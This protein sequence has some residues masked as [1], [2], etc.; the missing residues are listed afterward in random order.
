MSNIEEKRSNIDIWYNIILTI[1][2]FIKT[3][4]A[5]FFKY[6]IEIRENSPLCKVAQFKTQVT[7][8]A[9]E[10]SDI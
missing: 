2:F 7:T 1:F 8:G 3:K 10:K 9:S 5:T 6:K 4:K